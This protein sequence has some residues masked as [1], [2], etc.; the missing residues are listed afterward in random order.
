MEAQ[1]YYSGEGKSKILNPT[2]TSNDSWARREEEEQEIIEARAQGLNKEWCE[3]VMEVRQLQLRDVF[4]PEF[5]V[6]ADISQNINDQITERRQQSQINLA[7]EQ[8]QAE[9]AEAQR[10]LEDIQN[11]MQEQEDD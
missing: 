10:A 2:Q 6:V 11:Q 3:Q 5:D 1:F 9:E 4:D 7:L 8:N